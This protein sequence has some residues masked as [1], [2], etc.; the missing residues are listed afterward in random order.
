MGTYCLLRSNSSVIIAKLRKYGKYFFEN[1][2]S[3]PYRTPDST[4]G[5]KVYFKTVEKTI[6]DSGTRND[7]R[8]S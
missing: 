8:K 3:D 6:V 5:R 4:L 7:V 2:F 1:F